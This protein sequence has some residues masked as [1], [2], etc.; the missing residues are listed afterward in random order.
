M[1]SGGFEQDSHLRAPQSTDELVGCRGVSQ[2]SPPA[3]GDR[4]CRPAGFVISRPSWLCG[5]R[6]TRACGRR[7]KRASRGQ[8]IARQLAGGDDQR[9]ADSRTS[10]RTP[11][12]RTSSTRT[13]RRG[14]RSCRRNGRGGSRRS[15]SVSTVARRS[16]PDAPAGR[17]QH[18]ARGHLRP[19]PPRRSGTRT[20]S[21][22]SRPVSAATC[23]SALCV[24]FQRSFRP[25]GL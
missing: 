1:R 20:A 8:P 3:P 22:P 19:W 14:R 9:R 5:A 25:D 17:T 4:S 16:G 6:R 7:V 12:R 18:A 13:I 10:S 11:P 24:S 23:I 2:R 21:S 15:F